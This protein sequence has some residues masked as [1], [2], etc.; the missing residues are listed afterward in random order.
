MRSILTV[1]LIRPCVACHQSSCFLFVLAYNCSLETFVQGITDNFS[2][3]KQNKHAPIAHENPVS[4]DFNRYLSLEQ[5]IYKHPIFSLYPP[6]LIS[7]YCPVPIC[8]RSCILL[9]RGRWGGKLCVRRGYC[10]F[11][12]DR[13]RR[14]RQGK[15]VYHMINWLWGWWIVVMGKTSR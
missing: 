15:K 3:P 1:V 4:R 14:I 13:F 11:Q 8:N 2:L 6:K 7:N 9:K 5:R 10:V 12:I